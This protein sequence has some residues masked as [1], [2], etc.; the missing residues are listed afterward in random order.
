MLGKAQ[1]GKKGKKKDKKKDKGGFSFVFN[2][3]DDGQVSIFLFSFFSF[4]PL[5]FIPF[6]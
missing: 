1:K 3:I 6:I 2:L 5:R 4:S